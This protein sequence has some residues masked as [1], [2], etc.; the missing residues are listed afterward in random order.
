LAE[1]ERIA[2][3][4]NIAYFFLGHPVYTVCDTIDTLNFIL[5]IKWRTSS[6][7]SSDQWL[8]NQMIKSDSNVTSNVLCQQRSA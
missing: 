2:I 6:Y 3:I 7:Y 8:V 5:P 1:D 4:N